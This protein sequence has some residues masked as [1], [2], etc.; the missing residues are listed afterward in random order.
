MGSDQWTRALGVL[1]SRHD[2]LLREEATWRNW[3]LQVTDSES[4]QK[5]QA[6]KERRLANIPES[7]AHPRGGPEQFVWQCFLR[8]HYPSDEGDCDPGIR[9]L[10]QVLEQAQK[11]VNAFRPLLQRPIKRSHPE[12]GALVVDPVVQ[13][14][15]TG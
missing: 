2:T 14:S 1:V 4:K 6:F 10:R 11:S 12:E 9:R 15:H 5:L 7:G 13:D 3:I 8:L